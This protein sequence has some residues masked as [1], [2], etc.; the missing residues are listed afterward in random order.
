MASDNLFVA[1]GVWLERAFGLSLVAVGFA[2]TVIGCAELLGE[3]L[4]AALSDR[5]GLRRSILLGGALSGVC[6]AVLPV[7]DIS[8][9]F[10]LAGL[11]LVFLMG[12]FTIVGSISFFTEILPAARGTM[13]AGYFAAA[14][15]G[16]VIG[17]L[18]SGPLWMAGG[19]R[20]V[21]VAS[22]LACG[23]GLVGIVWGTRRARQ[24]PSDL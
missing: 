19:I 13:M 1:Y 10:A 3:G 24:G 11:F 8:L 21:A 16:R 14:S 2:T 5:L 4:I 7:M 20:A 22:A 12:E 18:M 9:P 6:Y 23:V 17:A 15:M